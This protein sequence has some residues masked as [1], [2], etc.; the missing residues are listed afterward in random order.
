MADYRISTTDGIVVRKKATRAYV[1]G[2]VGRDA[3]GNVVPKSSCD[4]TINPKKPI[5]TFD[6]NERVGSKVIGW[7]Y[8]R[9]VATEI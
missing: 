5:G 1:A 6:I 9:L 4:F 7:T 8:E 3:N 2:F